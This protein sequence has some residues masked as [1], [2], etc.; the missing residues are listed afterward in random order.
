MTVREREERDCVC[1]REEIVCVRVRER[2]GESACVMLLL[3]F[4]RTN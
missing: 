2:D 3:P 1:T 4:A